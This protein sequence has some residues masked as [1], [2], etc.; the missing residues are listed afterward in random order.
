MIAIISNPY[1]FNHIT[2][3]NNALGINKQV[4]VSVS[5]RERKVCT[6]SLVSSCETEYIPE[7]ITQEGIVF[8]CNNL[9]HHL[10]HYLT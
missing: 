6:T 8:V 7:I 5:G 2:S 10:H 1:V 3:K 4:Q 9:C